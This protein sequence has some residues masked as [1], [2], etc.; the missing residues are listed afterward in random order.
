MISHSLCCLD[1]TYSTPVDFQRLFIMLWNINKFIIHGRENNCWLNLKWLHGPSFSEK[2]F[3]QLCLSY[4]SWAVSSATPEGETWVRSRH[5][6]GGATKTTFHKIWPILDDFYFCFCSNR[7]FWTYLFRQGISLWE[8]F[9]PQEISRG[10]ASRWGRPTKLLWSG[11]P[12]KTQTHKNF[13]SG[14]PPPP[15]YIAFNGEAFTK[16]KG[17]PLTDKIAKEA[18]GGHPFFTW[19]TH[20]TTNRIWR[21]LVRHGESEWNQQNRFCGWF[22]ANLSETGIKVVTKAIRMMMVV[23]VVIRF[24]LRLSE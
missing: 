3:F 18:F 2:I 23:K 12:K 14:D 8:R 10:G 16:L 5:L 17:A 7:W 1:T 24:L 6:L 13:G 15:L 4:V 20:I 11:T 19:S 22:D 21:F 9:S